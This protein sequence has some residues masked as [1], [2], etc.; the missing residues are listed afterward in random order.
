V[1]PNIVSEFGDIFAAFP[2]D[3]IY[4]GGR[5]SHARNDDVL[6]ADAD[7]YLFPSELLNLRAIRYQDFE[8][9]KNS[10]HSISLGSLKQPDY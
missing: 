1:E 6:L 4:N 9:D 2:D 3:C 8:V 7:V 10:T 5:F